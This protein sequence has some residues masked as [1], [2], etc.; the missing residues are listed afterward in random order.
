MKNCYIPFG[1][2]VTGED[3][4]GLYTRLGE[5]VTTSNCVYAAT[6]LQK[7]SRHLYKAYIPEGTIKDCSELTTASE[8]TEDE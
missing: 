7:T 8:N 2:Y 5:L 3:F 4:C 6:F 1:A